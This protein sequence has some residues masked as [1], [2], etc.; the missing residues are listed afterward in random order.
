MGL[1]ER[2]G[3]HTGPGGAGA[4]GRLG[5]GRMR[6]APYAGVLVVLVIALVAINI[7]LTSKGATGVKPGKAIPPFAL[8]LAAGSVN[9]DADIA[10]HPNSGAAGRTSACAERGAGILNVCQLYERGPLVLALFIDA[11]SCPAVLAEMQSL[12]PA[13]PGVAFAGVAIKGRRAPLRAL[14][15]ARGLTRVQV[16]FDQDGVLAGLYSLVTCPQVTFVLPGGVAQ[17]A[18]LLATPSTSALRGRVRA[19]VA[20]SVA[21]GWRAPKR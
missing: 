21:R 6:P 16:G 1:S 3:A 7:A 15:A 9:G 4:G 10:T 8:P 13:F 11:G 2:W 19:L 12:A 5:S 18:P 17:S 14:V 20:A